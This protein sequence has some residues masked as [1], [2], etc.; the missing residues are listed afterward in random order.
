ALQKEGWH[1]EAAN[2]LAECLRLQPNLTAASG[3][4]SHLFRRFGPPLWIQP[5]L[6]AFMPMRFTQ[7]WEENGVR[8]YAIVAPK[9][10]QALLNQSDPKYGFRFHYCMWAYCSD[11]TADPLK[12]RFAVHFQRNADASL[13]AKCSRVLLALYTLAKERLGLSPRFSEDG[14]VHVWLCTNG[15]AG[16][17]QW[18]Q[19]LYFYAIDAPRQPSEWIRQ[20]CH[21]YGHLVI[22]G[23]GPFDAPEEWANGL[24]G[25]HLFMRWLADGNFKELWNPSPDLQTIVRNGADRLLRKFVQTPPPI[26][27]ARWSADLCTALALYVDAA[28][29]PQL[30][31]EITASQETRT[32]QQFWA[33]YKKALQTRTSFG[34]RKIEGLE[35]FLV[36]I[37]SSGIQYSFSAENQIVLLYIE[38]KPI[39]PGAWTA[40]KTGWYKIR[41]APDNISS[42]TITQ[43]PARPSPTARR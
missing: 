6:A 41:C 20:L 26:D 39:K 21:E 24:I 35:I 37:F 29:G 42:I 43:K 22:P 14:V 36:P 7:T 5:D 12:L 11:S 25:E 8:R 10:P 18:Q 40:V 33:A 34:V 28:H 4:L 23:I 15:R 19:H 16:A 38:D 1:T 27:E 17:E 2:L 9:D 13:A 30:L 32:P 3:R 31:A